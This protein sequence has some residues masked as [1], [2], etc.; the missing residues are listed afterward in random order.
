MFA[1]RPVVDFDV[2]HKK[3]LL[4]NKIFDENNNNC[5][6]KQNQILSEDQ[7]VDRPEFNHIDFLNA[8]DLLSESE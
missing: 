6:Y 7:A 4:A 5:L 8:S 1:I 2:S 3:N